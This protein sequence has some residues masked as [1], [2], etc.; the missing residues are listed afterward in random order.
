M[1]MCLADAGRR[2]P[3]R[4]RGDAGEQNTKNMMRYTIPYYGVL[5]YTTI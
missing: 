5:C 2:P 3:L 1:Y 4:G